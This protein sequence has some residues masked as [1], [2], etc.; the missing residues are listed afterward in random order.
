MRNVAFRLQ[1]AAR[2]VKTMSLRYSVK[3]DQAT[4]LNDS[5]AKL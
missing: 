5:L 4:F 1:L 2:R 3:S